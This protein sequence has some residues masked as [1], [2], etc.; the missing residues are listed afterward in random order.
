MSHQEELM[1]SCIEEYEKC[2]PKKVMDTW[3][4]YAPK[5]LDMDYAKIINLAPD[6]EVDDIITLA[7]EIDDKLIE[8]FSDMSKSSDCESVK[9]AFSN[10]KKLEYEKK[11]NLVRSCVRFEDL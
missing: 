2:L 9:E 6:I 11:K 1:K 4:K 8:M 7:L 10:L 5:D 3:F